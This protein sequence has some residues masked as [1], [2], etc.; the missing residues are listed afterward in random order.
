MSICNIALLVVVAKLAE[1]RVQN[2]L[3]HI[4]KKAKIIHGQLKRI[5]TNSS[6]FNFSLVIVRASS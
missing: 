5:V 6:P 2:H 4:G 1:I 3:K